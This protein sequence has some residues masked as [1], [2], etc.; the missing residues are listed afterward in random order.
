MNTDSGRFANAAP[1]AFIPPM[2]RFNRLLLIVLVLAAVLIADQ[3]SK[4]WAVGNLLPNQRLPLPG[5]VD[6]TLIFN[7]SNAFGLAPVRGEATRWLLT[8]LNLIAAGA[9]TVFAWRRKTS[10]L[11]AVG[12]TLIAGGALG[13]AIDRMWL[14][15]VIDLFDAS[16]LRFPWVFNLA[17]VAIDIG[18]GCWLVSALKPRRSGRQT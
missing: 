13:N 7:H 9:L 15:V 12:M 10:V 1:D 18:I 2:P 4:L 5:P 14:G 3:A 16:S 11:T 17:D 6:L 8:T